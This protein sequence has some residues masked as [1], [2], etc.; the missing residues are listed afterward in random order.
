[1]KTRRTQA[2][3][4]INADSLKEIYQ[5]SDG[6]SLCYLIEWNISAFLIGKQ[7]KAQKY[8]IFLSS[9]DDPGKFQVAFLWKMNK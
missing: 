9:N 6:E 3:H 7:S 5:R 4:Q 8:A 2:P 1:M